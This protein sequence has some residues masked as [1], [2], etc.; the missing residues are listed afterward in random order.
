MTGF[1]ARRICFAVSAVALVIGV[2][3]PTSAATGWAPATR[4]TASTSN[5]TADPGSIVSYGT[6][7]GIAYIVRTAS[8]DRVWFRRSTDGGATWRSP[9]A[10]SGTSGQPINVTM[11]A[12]KAQFDIVYNII[13]G[14]RARVVYTRSTDSGKTWSPNVRLSPI[15]ESA[16]HPRVARHSSGRVVVVWAGGIDGETQHIWSRVSTNFG[17]SFAVRVALAEP[18]NV[19][20]AHPNVAIGSFGKIHVVYFGADT[21]LYQRSGNGGAS[22]TSP[23]QL[24]TSVGSGANVGPSIAVD[25]T[26]VLVA[27]TSFDVNTNE[28]LSYRFSSNSGTDWTSSRN[29]SLPGGK[30]AK[31]VAVSV[32][33][34]RWR[35]IY[36]RCGIN[37]CEGSGTNGDNFG[38]FRVGSDDGLHWSAEAELRSTNLDAAIP[39]GAV[40]TAKAIYAWLRTNDTATNGQFW[41]R[42]QL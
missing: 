38:V 31:A 11:S 16:W 40:G 6:T 37:F 14:G 3:S 25:G 39:L 32:H 30:E 7:V 19:G 27:Y 18:N 13:I 33:G 1:C 23:L 35:A 20:Y 5:V 34:G 28:W 10:I 42:R 41:I 26:H 36:N 8:G 12:S 2:M 21:V 4:V 17:S 24:A 29:L 22:W 9:K 15:A